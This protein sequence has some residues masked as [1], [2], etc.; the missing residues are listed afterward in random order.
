MDTMALRNITYGLYIIG[1][2]DG[3]RL[4]G[5]TVNTV[6]QV[7]SDP[8][9]IS[10]CI[11]HNNYTNKCIKE[12]KRFSVSILSEDAT[13]DT[14]GVFGFHSGKDTDKF[15]QV[16][17]ELSPG[18]LPV[19]TNG[20]SGWLECTV[21]SFLDLPTHTLFVGRLVDAK[22]ALGKPM[23]YSYYHTVVK[24]KTPPNAPSYEKPKGDVWV[25]SV[26]G[27]IYD[28]SQGPFEQL[29]ADWKCPLCF[30]EKSFFKKAS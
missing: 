13:G 20:I 29:P 27:Y 12:T 30:T 3:D 9:L 26:C 1:T 28:G 25:C 23:S 17:H 14:I 22:G 7:T 15:G 6:A 16:P 5:C 18:G 10:V 8:V 19:L 21:E 11:N 24:G 2:K 4:T